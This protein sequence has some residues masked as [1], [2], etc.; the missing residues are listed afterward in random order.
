MFY[1]VKLSEFLIIFICIYIVGLRE[2]YCFD[3]CF[4]YYL[5]DQLYCLFE[6]LYYFVE[7]VYYLEVIFEIFI[8][9]N[10]FEVVSENFNYQFGYKNF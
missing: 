7:F 10:I 5:Y 3:D 4:L 8:N 2:I 6:K 1:F 9:V